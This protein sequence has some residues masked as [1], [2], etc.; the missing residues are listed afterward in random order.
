M[1]NVLWEFE[2]TEASK[3]VTGVPHIK[4]AICM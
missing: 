2:Y 1:A 4:V 3:R